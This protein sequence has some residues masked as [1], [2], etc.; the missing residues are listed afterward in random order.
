MADVLSRES[1]SALM[2]RVRSRGNKST[3][4]RLI[5]LMR[6]GGIAGWRRGRRIMGKPDFVFPKARLAIFVDGDFWHGNPKTFRQPKDNFDFWRQKIARNRSRD[7][8]VNR[9]LRA[10]GWTV[11]RIW[12]SSLAKRPATVMRRLA[13]KLESCRQSLVGNG[14]VSLR[15]EKP[16]HEV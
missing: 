12:E 15:A 7:R 2:S 14:V 6:A 11:L 4:L 16:R 9:A 13:R 1:R 3:E 10:R 5:L 8:L